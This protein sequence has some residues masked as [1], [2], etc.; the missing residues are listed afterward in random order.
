VE[1]VE[2]TGKTV[3]EALEVALDRLGVA[4]PD[5]EIVVIEEPRNAMFGLRRSGARI[6]ARVRPVQARAKR[7][8]RRPPAGSSDARS[9][10]EAPRGGQRGGSSVQRSNSDGARERDAGTKSDPAHGSRSRG[11]RPPAQ[12]AASGTAAPEGAAATAGSRSRARSRPK[13]SQRERQTSLTEGP[14]RAIAVPK[15]EELSIETQAELAES[16]VRGVVEGFGFSATVESS[17]SDDVIQ[18]RVAG[19]G[20]GFLVGPRGA[21]VDAL[22]ELTRTAVQHRSDEHAGRIHVD[23]A[24]YRARRAAALQDFARRVAGEV[25]TSGE[26]QSLEPMNAVDRKAVHDAVHEVPGVATGSEGEDPRRYVVIRPAAE[27]DSAGDDAEPDDEAI[28]DDAPSE[29]PES[30][31]P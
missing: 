24:G 29:E 7:P 2:T 17:I 22:Q 21:T 16:F 13:S 19:E 8:S 14:N 23:V 20:L 28:D 30:D 11:R 6:R 9:R 12:P 26:A 10:R 15:E 4:E 5:A 3:A 25:L 18:V 31:S 27:V 1:W